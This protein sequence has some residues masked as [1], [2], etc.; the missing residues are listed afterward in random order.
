VTGSPGRKTLLVGLDGGTFTVLEPLWSSGSMP[1]LQEFV[2]RGVRAELASV[3][4]PLTPPAWTSLVTGRSPGHHGIF[5]FVSVTDGAAGL[6]YRMATSSDVRCETMWSI[7]SRQGRTVATLNFPV[8]FPPQPVARFWIAG[9]VPWRHLRRAVRPPELY[10][11]L[12]ALPGFDPKRLVLDLELERKAIQTLPREEYE[13]WITFHVERERR[14]LDVVRVLL[15]EDDCDLVAVLLDGMDKLM[16]LCW[17]FVDPAAGSAPA[18]AWERRIRELCLRYFETLDQVLAE[19]VELFGPE[20][21][22]F[23]ASDH[24]SGPTEELFYVNVW[25][26]ENGYLT[27]APDVTRDHEG[28]LTM[29]ESTRSSS[30][31]FDW[32]TTRAC[33]LTSGSNGIYVNVSRGPGDP[34]IAPADRDRLCTEIRE[35]LLAYRDPETGG[36]VVERVLT[37]EEAFAGPCSAGAPD[38]TLELRDHGFVSILRGEAPLRRR[39]EVMGAHRPDGIFVAAGPGVRA[40]ERLPRLSIL[41][42]APIVLYSLGLP[43]PSDLEGSIPQLLFDDALVAEHPPTIGGPTLRLD[44][45]AATDADGYTEREEEI[46]TERLRALGYVE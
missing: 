28:N 30:T 19:L 6:T 33:A 43:L 42:V 1:F 7:A 46:L 39:A 9:F 5:D 38:L 16:H 22:V 25:L 21:R 37:R 10:D 23:I 41:D 17:R 31:L 36:Q 24:G 2:H 34:G 45:S 11:R 14:W 40:G 4:P 32:R 12:V 8:A 35:G 20:A 3:I 26:S 27:W 15:D 13:E 18:S 29:L 44:E